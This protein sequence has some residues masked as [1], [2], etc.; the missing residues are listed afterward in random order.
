MATLP[1]NLTR[2][3]IINALFYFIVLLTGVYLKL[4]PVSEGPPL[5]IY[6]AAKNL[7]AGQGLHLDEYESYHRLLL[8]KSRSE[9]R[10]YWQDM[11]AIDRD[12]TRIV[13]H[14]HL[15][16][17]IVAPFL[18]IFGDAG[19]DILGALVFISLQIGI[20]MLVIELSGREISLISS[21]AVAAGTPFIFHAIGT[22]YDLLA[23]SWVILSI[24]L[25][26]KYPAIAGLLLGATVFFRASN[27]LYGPLFLFLSKRFFPRAAMR[28]F[29]V[30]FLTAIAS[31]LLYNDAI[32]GGPFITA[33]NRMPMYVAGES[34]FNPA[35]TA[36]S[37]DVL[38]SGWGAKLFAPANGFFPYN[39]GLLPL[40]LLP[41]Y[42]KFLPIKREIL[43]FL[44]TVAAQA[45]VIFS[46]QGWTES[47]YGNR[48]LLPANGL[49]AVLAVVVLEHALR[50]R[51]AMNAE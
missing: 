39:T 7:I 45:A 26:R 11:Y 17:V 41:F 21:I 8:E 28:P 27:I 6:L 31:Y 22:D 33:H 16:I 43:I 12:G 35:P 5:Q 50:R 30:G 51:P 4:P 23:A 3:V 15:M 10:P 36:F 42:W 25:A 29:L 20:Y 38:T 2:F 47:A 37:F 48:Y 18:A 32:W 19:L 46:Y 44:A 24:A 34:P 9:G 14:A 13:K 1:K 49:L 40:L